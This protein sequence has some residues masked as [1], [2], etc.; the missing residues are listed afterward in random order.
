MS[1]T[2]KEEYVKIF[3]IINNVF[4]EVSVPRIFTEEISNNN[5]VIDKQIAKKIAVYEKFGKGSESMSEKFI[6]RD[7]YNRVRLFNLSMATGIIGIIIWHISNSYLFWIS[8]IL[9]GLSIMGF[10]SQVIIERMGWGWNTWV[11]E[12]DQVTTGWWINHHKRTIELFPGNTWADYLS[13]TP[14]VLAILC[15]SL[16]S[17]TVDAALRIDFFFIYLILGTTFVLWN[18]TS[19][20]LKADKMEEEPKEEINKTPHCWNCHSSIS[21]KEIFC[22]TCG[23]ELKGAKFIEK[24][25]QWKRKL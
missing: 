21:A 16:L 7:Y 20:G 4:R 10:V 25:D 2:K 14:N 24:N 13:G 3:A 8:I 9:S 19:V 18:I 23:V 12:S 22:L 6:I 17:L 15:L 11:I 5:D 1:E